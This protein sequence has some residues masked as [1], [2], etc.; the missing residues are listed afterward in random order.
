MTES[1]ARLSEFL[2]D[3]DFENLQR[4]I[5]KVTGLNYF[6]E[7]QEYLINHLEKRFTEIGIK[8]CTSYLNLLTQQKQGEVELD[9]LITYLTIGETYFFRHKEQFDSLREIILPA[10]IKKNQ[11]IKR[12]R[13][14]CAGCSTGAEPYS[15]AILL[16]SDFS[17]QIAG[18]DVKIVGTDINRDVLNRANEG[19]YEDWSFRLTQPELRQNNFTQNGQSWT[20]L[21]EFKQW[22]SFQ[23]HNLVKQ[24]FTLPPVP[25]SEYDIIF[26][27]NVMIYFGKEVI[28]Q[29][30]FNFATALTEQGWLVIG[31]AEYSLEDF[32]C[33]KKVPGPG[34][35]L[36]Q[37]LSSKAV[38]APV[39]LSQPPPAILFQ[40]NLVFQPSLAKQLPLV[41]KPSFTPQKPQPKIQEDLLKIQKLSDLGEFEA[42]HK[43]SI[44]LVAANPLEPLPYFYY[45][46]VLIHLKRDSE[47]EEALNKAIYL[48]RDFIFAHYYLGLIQEEKGKKDSA[49]KHFNNVL[50]LLDRLSPK[51]RFPE[52]DEITVLEL[53]ELVNFYLEKKSEHKGIK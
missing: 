19:K 39:P 27:R 26:C 7:K 2:K 15:V 40:P 1:N 37:K 12:L 38:P 22:V 42:A 20:I 24:P 52:G 29:L 34:T 53:R 18:W 5:I 49:N 25:I 41:N 14:W 11:D 21:R 45:A 35:L 36:Y 32:G 6:L 8:D 16:K 46:L 44:F 28:E 48:K 51:T 30:G 10:V 9:A 4:Y 43:Q 23:Y 50:K 3:P 13:I 47:A 17:A 31:H 33:L